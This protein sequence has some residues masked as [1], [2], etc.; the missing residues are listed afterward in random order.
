MSA[1]FR[2]LRKKLKGKMTEEGE[3]VAVKK[4]ESNDNRE[5]T[6]VGGEAEKEVD[7][8]GNDKSRIALINE[9]LP[10]EMLEKIFSYLSG[11]KD[12]NTVMLVCKTWN[13][14]GEA[15]ALWSWFKIKKH[16]QLSLKRLQGCREIT[17][18]KPWSKN[19]ILFEKRKREFLFAGPACQEILQH[20]GLKKI[21]LSSSEDTWDRCNIIDDDES[22][23]LITQTFA[24]MEEIEIP[25][26]GIYPEVRSA[27]GSV[28]R[29][30]MSAILE[31]P[32]NLRR[33][34]MKGPSFRMGNDSTNRGF[35]WARPRD[36]HHYTSIQAL[37]SVR[38]VTALDKIE[39][40]EVQLCKGEVNLLLEAMM[41]E[42]TSV[43][44]L[45]LLGKLLLSDLE[46]EYLY[47]VFDKLKELCIASDIPRDRPLPGGPPVKPVP[48]PYPMRTLCEKIASGTNLKILRLCGFHDLSEVSRITLERAVTQLEEL[49]L[50]RWTKSPPFSK[51][52]LVTIA[53]A[54]ATNETSNLRKLNI[55]F[56]DLRSVESWLLVEMA[57]HVEDLTL[58]FSRGEERR[59]SE[60]LFE[61]IDRFGPG[62][63]KSLT[64]SDRA[65]Y[66]SKDADVLARV[67]NKLECFVY[68]KP[69]ILTVHQTERILSLALK[70]RTL[71]KLVVWVPD[72]TYLLDTLVAEAEKIIPDLYIGKPS[73]FDAPSASD[74][75]S[76]SDSDWCVYEPEEDD[77]YSD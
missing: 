29:C 21:T 51:D 19:S 28:A 62:K 16:S 65:P 9:L 69:N 56:I 70:K 38:L 58:V 72:Y 54:I 31:K 53:T 3:K 15:P 73:Y 20:P 6:G 22:R 55:L 40:L 45:S 60:A 64:L 1:L 14:V 7:I 23:D 24:K 49:E 68:V 43:K 39:T 33:L 4:G 8:E 35:S 42:E 25:I 47:G 10:A 30:V 46:P 26:Y 37:E 66:N 75:D 5:M 36:T 77:G 71:R 2:F 61:R 27:E 67:V 41:D 13:T 50:S 59:W 32:N 76:S 74:S 11:I 63:L 52:D 17:I 44:S 34:V 48:L 18:E 57:A 12:L